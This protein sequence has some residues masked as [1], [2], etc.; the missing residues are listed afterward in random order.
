MPVSDP[1]LVSSSRDFPPSHAP[2][3]LRLPP[4]VPPRQVRCA[5]GAA[6]PQVQGTQPEQEGEL[7]LFAGLLQGSALLPPPSPSPLPSLLGPLPLSP[8]LWW[9]NAGGMALTQGLPQ[10]EVLH[11]AR[12]GPH[13]PPPLVPQPPPPQ[14]HQH[15][16]PTSHAVP[17]PLHAFLNLLDP[18]AL[19]D[20]SKDMPPFP[21]TGEL[22]P[23]RIG[24]KREVGTSSPPAAPFFSPLVLSFHA[25]KTGN[26]RSRGF[27]SPPFN[28]R[29]PA[30]GSL[31]PPELSASVPAVLSGPHRYQAP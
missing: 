24:P 14:Q 1:W 25:P 12:K 16:L 28:P 6:M 13:P 18:P 17:R 2:K 10:L 30:V 26:L 27:P 9:K 5:C 15:P 4:N 22:R 3:P 21:W 8:L 19:Q 20:R 11:Q 29:F 7:F 23:Y 31:P